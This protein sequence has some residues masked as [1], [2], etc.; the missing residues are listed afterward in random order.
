M[1]ASTTQVASGGR[2]AASVDQGADPWSDLVDAAHAYMDAVAAV[3]SD[4]DPVGPLRALAAALA[5]LTPATWAIERRFHVTL[6]SVMSDW[7]EI[8]DLGRL[9]DPLED[10]T[11]N[12]AVMAVALQHRCDALRAGRQM[13][14]PRLPFPSDGD[15]PAWE[16]PQNWRSKS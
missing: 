2:P 5:I 13:R 11:R 16:P 4:A 10:A 8:D 9:G 7:H 1:S 6:G 15:E 3:P 12:V 14:V